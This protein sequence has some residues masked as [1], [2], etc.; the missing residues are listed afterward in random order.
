MSEALKES[1]KSLDKAEIPIGCVIVKDGEVIGRG[2]NAREELNQA[3]MHAEVMAIQ[4]ANRTVGNWRLLD[5]TLFVTIEPCVMCSGAIGLARIPKVIY[6]A[7]NQKFGG[8]GSLYDILRDE[9]LNHRVEVETGVM[10]EECAK[11]MQDFSVRVVNA[12]KKPND[13]LNW[14]Q[15]KICKQKCKSLW[16]CIFEW[17]KSVFVFLK[18][19]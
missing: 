17:K 4:E 8:A 5:C 12:K 6:G 2:H 19:I 1:E 9:R 18:A 11:I 15:G 3:I 16:T 13:W 14:K 10:E 7:S